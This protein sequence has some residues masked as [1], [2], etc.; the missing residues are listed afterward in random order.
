MVTE[1]GF[2]TWDEADM[3]VDILQ[4]DI[5]HSTYYYS[6][7]REMLKSINEDGINLIGA[8]GWSF[9]DNWEWGEYND[10]YGVQAF[11]RSTLERVYKRSIFDY[12]DYIQSHIEKE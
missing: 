10:R 4:S 7:L 9:V 8:I 2:P 12:V 3:S 1:F 6:Y 11:N 5:M